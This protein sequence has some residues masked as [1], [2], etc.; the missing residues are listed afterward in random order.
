MNK[1][2]E[3]EQGHQLITR[4][5]RSHELASPGSSYSGYESEEEDIPRVEELNSDDH[6][7]MPKE[8]FENLLGSRAPN[9]RR[10]AST[11]ILDRSRD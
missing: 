3:K 6:I 11:T 10:R 4:N 8:R 1:Q 9:F 5:I 7:G 2:K